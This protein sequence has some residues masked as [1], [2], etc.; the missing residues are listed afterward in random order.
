M[1]LT[2]FLRDI[3][4]VD[5]DTKNASDYHRFAR[6]LLWCGCRCLAFVPAGPD[7]SYSE[8]LV[9]YAELLVFMSDAILSIVSSTRAE[10][11]LGSL[12]DC[13]R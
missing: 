7:G 1:N 8:L 10:S 11:G 5:E 6:V 3:R 9:S 13:N 2:M 12:N 4:Y